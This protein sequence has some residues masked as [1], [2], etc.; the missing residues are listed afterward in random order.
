MHSYRGLCAT[1]C[2]C[3]HTVMKMQM[4]IEYSDY[5]AESL[6]ELKKD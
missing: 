2:Q 6:K 1:L 4:E 3:M 5:L